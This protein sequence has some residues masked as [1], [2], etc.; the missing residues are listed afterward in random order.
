LI[1]WLVLAWFIG[2]WL[3]LQ[4]SS[5]WIL[6]I[7][8]AVIGLVAF[9]VVIWWFRLREKERAGMGASGGAGGDE[10]DVL[11]REAETRL[12]AS[13]LGRTASVGNLPLFLV[14]G[15][16]GA[17]KTTIVLHSGLEPELLAGQVGQDKVPLPTRTANLWYT[18]QFLFAEAGGSMLQ[19]RP[20]WTKLVRKLAPRQLH[21]VF[22]KGT[23]APRAALVCVDCESFMRPGAPEALAASVERMR[24]RLC[25]VSQLLGISLPVYVLFTRA[26]RLQ[27]FQDYV[28]NLTQDEAALVFGA[29]F[30]KVSYSTGVYAEQET[31]RV[32]GAFDNLFQSLADRRI[33]LLGQEFDAARLPTTYEFPREFRKL[34]AL[35]VQLLVDLCKPSQLRTGPFFRGFYFTGVRPVTI[36]TGGP[37][38]V[39]EE[40]IEQPAAR[41]GD[42]GATGI[43]DIRKA[44]AMAAQQAQ[45]SEVGE[46]RRVPQWVFLPHVF[47]DVLL[48]DTSALTA[49]ASS[50]RTSVWRRILLASAMVLLLIFV[51]GFIV[52]FFRNKSLES[53]VVTASQGISDV[54]LT[55]QQLPTVDMLNRLETLRQSVNTLSDYQQNGAP[56]SMRWGLYVGNSLYPD[57]RR[58]YFQYFQHL[59]FGEAQANLVQTLSS[60]PA[61]PGPNDQYGPAYDT[62]KAY[63]ITTT[64]HDKSTTLFLS[65][66]LMKAWAAGRDIDQDRTDLAQKQFDFYSEQL[67]LENP[68]SSENDTLIVDRAR[69]YISQFSGVERVY[70]FMLAEATKADPPVNFNK[71]YPGAAD[72]VV[73]R[74]LVSGAF[75]KGGWA[76]MQNALQNL[77]K[78]FSGE[79]WVVGEQ[80]S[81]NVDLIKTASDLGT[82]YRQDFIGQWRAFLRGGMVIRYSGLPDAS[83]KLLKLSGNQSPLLALF[84]VAAQN[85]AVNQPDVVKAF[86]SVQSVVPANCQD[87]FIGDAN[88]PYVGGL[89]G[90]QVC[91]DAANNALSD[92]DAAKAKCAGDASTAQLAVNQIGQ[93]FRPDQEGHVDQTVQSLLLA[94]IVSVS[95]VLKPGPVS[96]AGLCAQLSPIE[97]KFPFNPGATAEATPQDIGAVFDPSTGALSQFYNSALKNLLLPQGGSYIVNPSATQAVNPAFLAF[98]NRA[99]SIQRALYGGAPG[100]L[101][102]KYAL[103]PH[104]TDSVSGM[105]MNVDGQALNFSG[106]NSSYQQFTWPGVTGQG[107]TLTVKIQGGSDLSFPSYSGT[108]GVFHFFA[109]AD[110]TQ[111]NGNVYNVEWVLRVA[112]GRP[113]TAPNGKPVTVQFDLDPLGAAP[114]L[115]KGYFTSLRCVS[116]VAK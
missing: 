20:R 82:R 116:S 25:E 66:V 23:P 41:A 71:S 86:Q 96:G 80:S 5:L 21:S 33:N 61:T 39:R 9:V 101:Q 83:Q 40:P 46:T 74:V 73:D 90:L 111:A 75:T 65:P 106:G 100:Q 34:R 67:K 94:P 56:W 70:Q 16:T 81:S 22:G 72:V 48:K 93:G 98:F 99:A 88:K 115:Q 7:A 8:L 35:L 32:T 69:H 17:A 95:A 47:S 19:D 97:S 102:F 92:K 37:A 79:Q 27:F 78:F 60:L 112:G 45:A 43:F 55:G 62:L 12:Q 2:T 29:T 89:S 113:L 85:T 107:V 87:Q 4:G 24:T 10:I 15:E 64:N 110:K 3:H 105:T 30:P 36:T 54:T 108:W 38:L 11:I 42:L 63:L 44:R 103:R 31:A 59:L 84:C 52:S 77:P 68:Y 57:V 26:D 76:F 58:I 28:R 14:L 109:D 53:Q 91:L 6:R 18:R 1:G 50:T 49:S 114:I 51:V 13:K 104:P